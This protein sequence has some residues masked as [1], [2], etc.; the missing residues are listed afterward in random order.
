MLDVFRR[1]SRI[2]ACITLPIG[3][4]GLLLFIFAITTHRPNH[5]LATLGAVEIPF[6]VIPILIILFVKP[7]PESER[8]QRQEVNTNHYNLRLCAKLLGLGPVILLAIVAVT[9]L[10][11]VPEI[12]EALFAG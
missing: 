5:D 12:L 8:L 9:F 11:N 2:I 10:Y 7:A 3:S 4:F 1:F 6:L